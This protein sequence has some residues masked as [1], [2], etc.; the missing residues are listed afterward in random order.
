MTDIN[1]RVSSLNAQKRKLFERLVAEKKRVSGEPID[2]LAANLKDGSGNKDD[3]LKAGQAPTKEK[4]ISRSTEFTPSSVDFSVI[5]FSAVPGRS[6]DEQYGL[7]LK[8]VKQADMN[9]YSAVWIPERHFN[10][11]GGLYPNPATI[12]AALAMI[13]ER[14][15]LRAGSVV[16]PIHHPL[17]VAEEWAVVDNLSNG[18]AGIS[19]AIGWARDDFV[20]FPEHYDD[21]VEKTIENI[22]IIQKLWRGETCSFNGIDNEEVSLKT[23]PR[24]V[25]KNLNVWL[26]A[27]SRPDTFALA[28]KHGFNVLT[29]LTGQDIPKLKANIQI[30]RQALLEYGF[31]ISRKK[32]SVMLHTFLGKDIDVVKDT[33]RPYMKDYL[34]A[35][36]KLHKNMARSRNMTKN[37]NEEDEDNLLEY[38]FG[39]YFSESSL[40]GTAETCEKM[41]QRLIA[42][43]VN[44]FACLLDFGLPAEAV[45]KSM[46]LFDEVKAQFCGQHNVSVANLE[47]A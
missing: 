47:K 4:A 34:A 5:F 43:G 37:I 14:V 38:S 30:Y 6:S 26:T 10:E 27:S 46:Q 3:G 39:R 12:S 36:L 23:F 7:L 19:C 40:L 29:A 8:L 22:E 16:I 18:R 24:P 13:T 15:Q 21:R 35:S 11:F 33:V 17:R 45:L 1:D 41:I 31:D 9:N 20:Y 28:G 25:S 44:D 2:S 32:V 42:I